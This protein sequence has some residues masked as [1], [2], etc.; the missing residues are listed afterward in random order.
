[1]IGLYIELLIANQY[2]A[3]N[4]SCMYGEFVISG[5]YEVTMKYKWNGNQHTANIITTTIIIFT[6]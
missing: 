4:I 1:M 6:T 2:I 5:K 3:K